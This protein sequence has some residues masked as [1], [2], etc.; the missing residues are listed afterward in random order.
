MGRLALINNGL[1]T[2][3]KH[4]ISDSPSPFLVW[5]CTIGCST[6]ITIDIQYSW[7]AWDVCDHKYV[8]DHLVD[9]SIKTVKYLNGPHD[10]CI[11]P[12]ISPYIRSKNEINSFLILLVMV[13]LLTFICECALHEKSLD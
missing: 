6:S 7:K 5:K 12:Q 3:F 13:L 11:K 8:C 9:A 1:A 4:F 10:V 2:N